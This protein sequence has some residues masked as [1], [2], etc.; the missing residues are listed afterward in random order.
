MRHATYPSNRPP[1]LDYRPMRTL[2]ALVQAQTCRCLL[3]LAA[4]G[5]EAA[6]PRTAHQTVTASASASV[7]RVVASMCVATDVRRCLSEGHDAEGLACEAAFKTRSRV[8]GPDV[9]FS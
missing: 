9:T 7:A 5:P 6:R 2:A 4:A 1:S 8:S 3:Q